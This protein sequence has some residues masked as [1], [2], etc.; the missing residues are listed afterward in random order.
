[1][2]EQALMKD[3]L[4]KDAVLGIS[5]TL[6]KVMVDFPADAFIDDACLGL[7]RLELKQRVE[8]LIAIL[9]TYLPT[10]FSDAA[11]ILMALKPHWPAEAK[12]SD[13]S[14]FAAWPVIDYVGVYGL[15]DPELALDVLERL[16]SLFSAEFAIRPFV[17]THFELT[18]QRMLTWTQHDDEHVR[19]LASE[20]CRPRLP[21]GTQ[22]KKL[23]LDPEPVFEILEQLKDDPSL[24][25][26]KSVAN[27]L[28]DI[29]KDHPD[30][31]TARCQTWSNDASN[32]RQWIIKHGLRSLI[33]AGDACAFDVLGY[34]SQPQVALL[35]FQLN[36]P[37]ISLGQDIEMTL[38]LKSDSTE[39]Q[40][41]VLDYKVYHVKANGK[42]TSKV[43]KWKTLTLMP[44]EQ[45]DL[46]KKHPIKPISTRTYYSGTHQ[47]EIVINGRSFIQKQFELML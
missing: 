40:T 35:G 47:I 15:N 2:S 29:A 46:I 21:W 45:Y 44:F 14:S 22:I 4:G 31:V 5:Q 32:Q 34:S 3:K 16:T 18:H 39:R 13:W 33:K 23:R 17:D 26:R 27:N 19:R 9:N 20:G 42:L 30:L 37:S 41:V 43:F 1:M 28:N 36:P 25:V 8:H 12:Q 11:A 38:S 10:K 6:A 7:E 24:Y